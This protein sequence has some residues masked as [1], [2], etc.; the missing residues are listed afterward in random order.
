MLLSYS[1]RLICLALVSI[2]I[3]QCV[4]EAALW[5]LSPSIP[6]IS[7]NSRARELTL[8]LTQISTH[9]LALLLTFTVLVPEYTRRETNLDLERVGLL[10]I[11]LAAIVLIRYII[12]IARALTIS[13]RTLSWRRRFGTPLPLPTSKI[14]ILTV[15]KDP[16]LA[17]VGLIAPSIVIS[18]TLLYETPLSP[19]ALEVAIAHESSHATHRDNLKLLLLTCLPHLN[20]SSSTR[21]TLLR[22]WHSMAEIAADNE[23][24]A[25]NPIRAILLAETLLTVARSNSQ[26][27]RHL[28]SAALLPHEEDLE[29]RITRLLNPSALIAT[30][31]PINKIR[32]AALLAA[33]AT[34]FTC[35][36]SSWHLI[37]ECLFHLG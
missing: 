3:V 29:N 11:L 24:A 5:L 14:P 32:A 15:P 33:V 10:C 35:I 2:G 21:P 36:A 13:A 8:F 22:Q 27:P 30:P 20:L 9:P 23:A 26:N 16:P 4:L 37:A 7:K 6:C 18:R 31:N 12:A 19:S 1:W 34:L 17:L 28:C 25:E